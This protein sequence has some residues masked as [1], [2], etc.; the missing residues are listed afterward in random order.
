MC[1]LV[2]QDLLCVCVFCVFVFIVCLCFLRREYNSK[3]VDHAWSMSFLQTLCGTCVLTLFV[4]TINHTAITLK[5]S[6][7]FILV[8]LHHFLRDGGVRR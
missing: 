1:S 3:G 4:V 6:Y 2:G 5:L 8:S 7:E